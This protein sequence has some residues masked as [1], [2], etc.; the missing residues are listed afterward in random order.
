MTTEELFRLTRNN[1][2]EVI[3]EYAK[4]DDI[5]VKD[6]W[7]VTL[8][9]VVSAKNYIELAK[10]IIS[11]GINVSI[12][13][14][15]GQT[16]LHYCALNESLEVGYEILKQKPNLALADKYGNQPLWSAVIR[17]PQDDIGLVKEMI[18]QGADANWKNKVD[19]SPLDLAIEMN[20]DEL[21]EI[22]QSGK[23]LP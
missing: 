1:Q 8:L 11:N 3:S 17:C 9:H 7:G 13:D 4:L 16:P 21:I 5:N 23:S 19:K 22:L 2:Q 10:S 12:Q 20:D 18:N 6:E 15:D 14:V